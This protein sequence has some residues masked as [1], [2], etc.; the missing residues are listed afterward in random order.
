MRER[1][2]TGWVKGSVD[3]TEVLERVGSLAALGMT[4]PCLG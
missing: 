3:S 2:R 4:K 1:G